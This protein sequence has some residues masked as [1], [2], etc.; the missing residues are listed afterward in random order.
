LIWCSFW[1]LMG[2]ALGGSVVWAVSDP[3]TTTLGQA[4]NHLK[5]SKAAEGTT[6]IEPN[7]TKVAPYVVEVIPHLKSEEERAEERQET[8]EKRHLDRLLVYW[9]GAL[10]VATFGLIVATGILGFF[11]WKQSVDMRESIQLSA[12]AARALQR[13][14]EAGLM[15]ERALVFA[16]FKPTPN[17]RF[18]IQITN[19]GKTPAIMEGWWAS[20]E[21][22]P[23]IGEEPANAE[24]EHERRLDAVVLSGESYTFDGDHPL[25]VG[26]CCFG[27]IKYIDVF[28]GHH[29]SRFCV[30]ITNEMKHCSKL[31]HPAWNEFD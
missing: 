17:G 2:F 24:S 23:P 8:T 25:T 22:L 31:G 7:G 11:G 9:T 30:R 3:S 18:Q 16:S 6:S 28:R 26:H 10:V 15:A 5:N 20:I 1:L 19:T 13:A 14:G 4:V 12:V 21:P 29:T 27:Y